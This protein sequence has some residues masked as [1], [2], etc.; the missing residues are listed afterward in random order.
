MEAGRNPEW[1]QGRCA[2]V[3]ARGAEDSGGAPGPSTYKGGWDLV[4]KNTDKLIFFF[5]TAC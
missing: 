5:A 1:Q 4:P 3:R 2:P